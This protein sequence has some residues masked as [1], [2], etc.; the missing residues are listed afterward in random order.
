M[1]ISLLD[2]QFLRIIRNARLETGEKINLIYGE[3]GSGK[4]TILEGIHMLARGKSF[5]TPK[6]REVISKNQEKLLV[7]AE[8]E[9]NNEKADR[10]GIEK[11]I[12]K[13]LLK[14]KHQPVKTASEQAKN[15]P[16]LVL[17]T[18]SHRL[19]DGIPRE[20][21]KWMDWFMFHV[22]PN[23]LKIWKSFQ[24]ALRQRNRLLR[25]N[26]RD[27]EFV[28]WEKKMEEDGQNLL[29]LCSNNIEK[30][31]KIF[32]KEVED[33]LNG[34]AEIIYQPGRTLEEKY[35]VLLKEQRA[36]DREKGYTGQGPHR[37]ELGFIFMEGQASKMLSR[38]QSKLYITALKLTQIKFMKEKTKNIPVLLIDDVAAELDRSSKEK[39][40]NKLISSEAQSFI[41][42]TEAEIFKEYAEA[43]FHVERG[44]VE[45]VI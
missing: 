41:T 33:L 40:I 21:R 1:R 37:A 26:A 2:L 43:M 45:K 31:N 30:I 11:S 27:M 4:T 28:P 24:S 10:I 34:Q 16:L 18:E 15:L 3:N 44:K 17:T 23:Y 5:R 25:E 20:R 42:T 32:Q 14:F 22:E 6:A 12:R 35:S 19:L 8:L 9:N 29:S 38:G 7:V 36:K 13:T 39:V